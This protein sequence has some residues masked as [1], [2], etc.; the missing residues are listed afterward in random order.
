MSRLHSWITDCIQLLE[1]SPNASLFDRRLVALATLSSIADEIIIFFS[2]DDPVKKT[3]VFDAKVQANL[4]AFEK[5][6][7]AWKEKVDSSIMN[8]NSQHQ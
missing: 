2:L 1:T 5:R 3:S 8:G 4:K 6:L 7:K